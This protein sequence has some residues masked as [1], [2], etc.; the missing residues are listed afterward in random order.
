[1][2]FIEV[3]FANLCIVIKKGKVNMISDDLKGSIITVV[4]T[5]IISI[6]GFIVTYSSMKKSFK[7]ELKRQRNSIMLEKMSVMPYEV[8]EWLDDIMASGKVENCE[9]EKIVEGNFKHLKKILNII[10][11]YGSEQAIKIV[12]LMQKENYIA[13][14][15]IECLDKYRMLSEYVL[16]ATQIKYDVTEILVSP[17]LWFQIHI[18]DYAENRDKFKNANNRL[19]DEL[20]LESE[21]KI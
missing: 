5:G 11:S 20:N 12:A 21:L 13:N 18:V 3:V 19:V 1:M 4:V 16:L 8:L 2:Y 17:E 15:K 7:N 14:R 6:I 10:Y 9:K